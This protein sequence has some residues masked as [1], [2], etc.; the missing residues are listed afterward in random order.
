M[1]PHVTKTE[2]LR[3]SSR[4]TTLFRPYS[5]AI[6][7]AS[8]FHG[9]FTIGTEAETTP[10]SRAKPVSSTTSPPIHL[11]PKSTTTPA[12]TY[13]QR[14]IPRIGTLSQ[15]SHRHQL[16]DSACVEVESV[17]ESQA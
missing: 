13:Q 8:R 17:L 14:P 2:E 1:T 11:L 12:S 7:A 4:C 10:A 5:L 16:L 15:R 6:N 9:P 3:L